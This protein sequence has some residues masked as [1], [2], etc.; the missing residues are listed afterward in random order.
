MVKLAYGFVD[1]SELGNPKC[2]IYLQIPEIEVYKLILNYE[3]I[4]IV[5]FLQN[6]EVV[7]GKFHCRRI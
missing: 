4:S 3:C 6:K 7:L 1:E 2:A 5:V